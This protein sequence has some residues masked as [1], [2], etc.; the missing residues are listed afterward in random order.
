[1]FC[2]YVS[3]L[4]FILTVRLSSAQDSDASLQRP[5]SSTIE[6][7]LLERINSERTQRDLFA[8]ERASDLNTLARKHSQHMA[9]IQDL[10]HLSS[11][12]ETYRQRLVKPPEIFL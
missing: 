12:G 4:V 3:L 7:K 5:D 1:M 9:E 2:L 8:L 6:N 10:T 11:S